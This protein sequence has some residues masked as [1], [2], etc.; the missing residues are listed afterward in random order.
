MKLVWF[1]FVF[2]FTISRSISQECPKLGSVNNFTVNELT[3]SSKLDSYYNLAILFLRSLSYSLPGDAIEKAIKFFKETPQSSMTVRNIWDTVTPLLLSQIRFIVLVVIGFL[4]ALLM[5]LVGCFCFWCRCLCGN[6]GGKRYQKDPSTCSCI[7]LGLMSVTCFIFLTTGV[8]MYSINTYYSANALPKMVQ[9]FF[10]ESE[11]T[12]DMLQSTIKSFTCSSINEFNVTLNE[13]KKSVEGIS[14]INLTFLYGLQTDVSEIQTKVM[15]FNET[16]QNIAETWS[17]VSGNDSQLILDY[18]NTFKN[19]FNEAVDE[20]SLTTVQSEAE[21]FSENLYILV[22]SSKNINQILDK[23]DNLSILLKNMENTVST[24]AKKVS[25][26]VTAELDQAQVVLRFT[27]GQI[28]DNTK[29]ISDFIIN[30]TSVVNTSLTDVIVKV[31]GPYSWVEYISLLLVLPVALVCLLMV[32]GLCLGSWSYSS[33][34]KPYER[35][36]KLNCAGTCLIVSVVILFLFSWFIMFFCMLLFSIGYGGEQIICRQFFDDPNM[37]GLDFVPNI[38]VQQNQ[39]NKSYSI[40]N[41]LQQCQKEMSFYDSFGMV[42]FFD[43]NSVKTRIKNLENMT[44]QMNYRNVLHF[45]ETKFITKEIQSMNDFVEVISNISHHLN[46][47]VTIDQFETCYE[48]SMSEN[49]S[50]HYLMA[51]AKKFIED[52]TYL[53]NLIDK[54]QYEIKEFAALFHFTRIE[55]DQIDFLIADAIF[56]STVDSEKMLHDAFYKTKFFITKNPNCFNLYRIYKNFGVLFCKEILYPLHGWWLSIGWCLMF[57]IP[58]ICFNISLSKYF[59]KM[60]EKYYIVQ[61]IPVDD[62]RWAIPNNVKQEN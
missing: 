28:Y 5:P 34:V 59:R 20:Q 58:A 25:D 40:K 24:V 6:C 33:K 15:K 55:A 16:L 13:V 7:T 46:L 17:K 35:S 12:V 32:F 49:A 50:G 38:T 41:I 29:V 4:F 31:N 30:V 37:P 1:L 42:D 14:D 18:L 45:N 52:F 22:E 60:D 8:T 26:N 19:Y 51:R 3:Y 39:K 61:N 21:Q 11:A 54:S 47:S 53:T 62:G 43:F 48:L 9:D 44:R 57:F 56:N 2:S 23:Y 27:S 10:A 36:N